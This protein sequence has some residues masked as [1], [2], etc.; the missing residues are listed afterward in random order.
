MQLQLQEKWG[1]KN[2]EEN[3]PKIKQQQQSQQN[4]V[5]S[6]EDGL[7]ICTCIRLIF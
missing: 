5:L 7:L 2:Y 6:C 3:G 4:G 1:G